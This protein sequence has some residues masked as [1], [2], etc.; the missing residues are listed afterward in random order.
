M[1]AAL[2]PN[3][4]DALERGPDSLSHESHPELPHIAA[5]NLACGGRFNHLQLKAG[6]F[7]L[8]EK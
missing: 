1:P 8:T 2:R 5:E 7:H 3:D 6:L 4:F